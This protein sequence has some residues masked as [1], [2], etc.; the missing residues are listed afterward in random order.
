ML[1]MLLGGLWHGAA[2]TFVIFGICHGTFVATERAFLKER[3]DRAPHWIGFA[4]VTLMW[5]HTMAIFRADD[6]FATGQIFGRMYG[7]GEGASE[8]MKSLP[9]AWWLFVLGFFC[10]HWVMWKGE[11]LERAA[12]IPAWTFAVLIGLAWAL[13]LP[14]VAGNYTPF[15]YFQF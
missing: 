15:I 4:Y 8:A 10:V 3:L 14:W 12:R 1:T 9:Q 7:F 5:V 6:L 2:W 11:I 13:A